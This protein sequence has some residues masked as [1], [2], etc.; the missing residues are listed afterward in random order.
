M[1]VYIIYVNNLYVYYNY[2]K[3]LF[4]PL[5]PLTY[6]SHPGKFYTR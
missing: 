3:I 6:T 5:S 2:I 1:Y 4:Q